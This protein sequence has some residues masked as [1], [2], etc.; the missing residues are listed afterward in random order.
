MSRYKKI[1]F[2]D[3][4]G[5]LN[6]CGTN[7][8]TPW[9]PDCIAE[10]NRVQDYIPGVVIVVTSEHRL[11][12]KGVK[13]REFMNEGLKVKIP[14]IDT[15]PRVGPDCPNRGEEIQQWL[16]ETRTNVNEVK[17]VIISRWMK[18]RS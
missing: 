10:L 8:S 15:T 9:D 1:I 3:I 13:I 18:N 5:V 14:V 11:H 16:D 4:D 2:L 7:L 12:Y 17:M 6:H